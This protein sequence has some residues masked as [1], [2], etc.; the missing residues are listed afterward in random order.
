MWVSRHIL[1]IRHLL[2]GRGADE[3]A[4]LFA[5]GRMQLYQWAHRYNEE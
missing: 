3:T 1:A 4:G 5:I 2:E